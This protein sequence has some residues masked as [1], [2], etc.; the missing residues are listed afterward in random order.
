MNSRERLLCTIAG[1]PTDRPAVS[2][3]LHTNF[4]K[5]F[6]R[7]LRRRRDRRDGPRLSG[8]GVRPDPSQ[9]HPG[10]RRFPDRGSRLGV[11][12]DRNRRRD[13]QGRHGF[14]SHSWGTASAGHPLRSPLCSTSRAASWSSR[15][16]RPF[17]DLD[18][19]IRYQPPVPKIDA[20]AIT[21]ARELVAD[22]GIVAPWAQGAFNEIAYLVRG[23]RVLLDPLDDEGFWRCTGLPLP[24]A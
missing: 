18:L 5:E 6:R 11:L 8:S 3:F 22:E 21:R 23:H 12:P 16:S 17:A 13:A 1:Q 14:C 9:L 2:P 24:R 15:R 10:V 7:V 4:I 19:C 20:S